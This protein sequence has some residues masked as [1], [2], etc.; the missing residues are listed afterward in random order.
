MLPCPMGSFCRLW[1]QFFEHFGVMD[2]LSF[3]SRNHRKL[4]K[5]VCG[6]IFLHGAMHF[7]AAMPSSTPKGDPGDCRDYVWEIQFSQI[8]VTK[9]LQRGV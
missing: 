7:L 9:L 1:G 5:L 6:H 8:S 3:V 4:F 2:L